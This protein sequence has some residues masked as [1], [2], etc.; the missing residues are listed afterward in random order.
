MANDP[1]SIGWM[2]PP[3]PGITSIRNLE[4]P[5]P[6]H[7][8]TRGEDGKKGELVSIGVPSAFAIWDALETASVGAGS[9]TR[10]AQW[11]VDP[12]NPL[13]TRVLVNRVWQQHFGA[14]LVVTANDFGL[15]GEPPSHPELFPH[16][17]RDER[18]TVVNGKL[19]EEV[20]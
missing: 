5:T 20:L 3:L 12:A 11:L 18:L 1:P 10:L 13:T 14:G 7:V 19:I 15:H 4:K 6:I 9:R 8:L 2:S 17:G 16:L